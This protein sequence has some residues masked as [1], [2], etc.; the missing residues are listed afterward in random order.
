MN[1]PNHKRQSNT[2]LLLPFY[3]SHAPF[4]TLLLLYSHDWDKLA[5]SMVFYVIKHSP[6]WIRPVV[7]ANIIDIISRPQEHSLTQLW[8]NGAILAVSIVQ[9]IPTHYLHIMSLSAATRQMETNVRDLLTRQLQQLSIGFYKQRSIG[10]LQVKLLR[11]VEEIQQLTSSIFQFLPSALLTILI[12]IAI[13]AMRAWKFLFFFAATVPAA[14]IL[15]QVLKKPIQQ[16]NH[17][18]RRQMEGMS[19]HLIEMIKLVPV[20]RAHGIEETEIDRTQQRLISVKRAAMSLDGINAITNASSWVTL[21]LFSAICLVTSAYMAYTGK[22]G[23]TSGDVILLTGYF[24]ALTNSIVQILAVL[25]QIGTG[26]ESIRSVGEIL[27][28]PDIELNQ[29]KQPV[30][31]VRGEFLFD[32]VSFIYPSSEHPAVDNISLH[33]KPGETIAFVGP[34]GA[35]KSTLLNLV[36]GFL[37]PTQ[38]QIYLDGQ[39]MNALD[40]RTYRQFVSVVPQETILFEGTVR[41]NVL[42]G[43]QGV[44]ERQLHQ[45][46][47]DA[48]ALEFILN[49]PQGLDTLIGENGTKLSGGQRQRLAI[50]RALVRH[51]KVLF[52]DE[53]TASVDTASEALIQEALERLMNNCTTFVVAHRLS[54]IRKADRI[55]VLDKGQIVEIGNHQQLLEK[56]GLYARLIA[57]QA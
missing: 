53:A 25:P 52:L 8:L 24:D 11:D 56:N 32:A 49:L 14:V 50:A 42:Y 47:Q 16:R 51:P 18:F 19:S 35:G 57:L 20:T 39:D 21:R 55:V 33:V 3:R 2:K 37:R 36:I 34:S 27:E 31:Q 43:L 15:V 13:T 17:I 28:C 12:A 44:S 1:G 26:F 9:N 48:N 6:E 46:I 7:I 23:I 38:G 5:L 29:G 4:K 41:E 30:R 40:L 10:V 22:M 45:A 54:T